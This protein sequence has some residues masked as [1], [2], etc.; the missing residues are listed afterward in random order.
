MSD[1][2]QEYLALLLEKQVLLSK[3]LNSVETF[4]SWGPEV[5]EEVANTNP[6]FLLVI[7]DTMSTLLDTLWKQHLSL[8]EDYFDLVDKIESLK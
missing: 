6:E 2:K 3:V 4:V 5:V 8:V 7:M 1:T